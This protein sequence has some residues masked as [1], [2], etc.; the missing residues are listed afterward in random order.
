MILL[1]VSHL[2]LHLPP[3]VLGDHYEI[4]LRPR[5]LEEHSKAPGCHKGPD[6]VLN[7]VLR[8]KNSSF[9]TLAD[10]SEM[11]GLDTTVDEERLLSELNTASILTF[12]HNRA[13]NA[14]PY[15]TSTV[16]DVV[17]LGPDG[18]PAAT[19]TSSTTTSTTMTTATTSTFTTTLT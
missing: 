13:L 2:L 19:S 1:C 15:H 9:T 17:S 7:I 3:P 18:Q 8:P 12:F 6:V 16:F 14:A 11:C 5:T 4:V 10:E